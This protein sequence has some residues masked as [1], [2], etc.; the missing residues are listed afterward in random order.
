MKAELTSA[1]TRKA[2]ELGFVSVGIAEAGAFE[3]EAADLQDWL[4][5]G[6]HGTMGWMERTAAKRSDILKVDPDARSVII[7]AMN[8]YSPEKHSDESDRAKISRYAWGD[9]YHEVVGERLDTL[10]DFIVTLA[11]NTVARRYVDTGPVMEKV[12]AARA[13]IGW[14]GK[15]TNVISREYGSWIFLGTV[16]TNLRLRPSPPGEDLCGTCTACLD[17]CPTDA[18]VQPYQL[19]A[20][21]CISYLTIEHNG[22]IPDEFHGRFENWVFGCDICQDVC[23]WNRFQ[24][25]TGE[26]AFRPRPTA[27]NP[28]IHELTEMSETEFAK[29]FEGSP[30]TRTKWSGLVRNAGALRR[31]ESNR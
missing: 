11:P 21:R 5:H 23:P 18:I 15:H 10:R 29:R 30:V 28:A 20:S 3:K 7:A 16:I 12:W 4:R 2:L 31:D 8:Y 6:Y 14:Q 19:D 24:K 13:G 27:L 22:T 26:P 1:I 25:I 9:D 17:A